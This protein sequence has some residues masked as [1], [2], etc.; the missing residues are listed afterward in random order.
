MSDLTKKYGHAKSGHTMKHLVFFRILQCHVANSFIKCSSVLWGFAF[1][2]CL[3]LIVLL[4]LWRINVY[5][6]AASISRM[7]FPEYAVHVTTFSW[8]FTIAC[9]LV[10]Y[11]VRVRIRVRIKGLWLD[12][13]SGWLEAMHSA[14][15]REFVL[16]SVVIVAL[17]KILPETTNGCYLHM[18]WFFFCCFVFTAV[19]LANKRC[20]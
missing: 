7:N 5:N 8:M 2:S 20:I 16:L 12:L 6:I 3:M 9:C 1:L 10:V 4:L 14:H 19:F 15:T 11:R 13:V 17:S 18:P